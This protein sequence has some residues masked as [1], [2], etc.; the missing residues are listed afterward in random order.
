MSTVTG[1]C[2][3]RDVGGL[4]TEDGR[5][6]RA[7][8]LYR[9]D[10]PLAGDPPPAGIAAWPPRT[11]L[12][13]RSTRERAAATHP[14]AVGTTV[15]LPV[16][17]ID[18][19]RGAGAAA[20][21]LPSGVDLGRWFV[22]LYRRWLREHPTQIVEAVTVAVRAEAP[23]LVHCAAGRDRTGV[24]TALLLRAAGVRRD[25]VVADYRR[26]EENQAL[27][28]D[29]HALAVGFPGGRNAL[30][31]LRTPEAIEHVLDVVDGHPGGTTGW[32][33]AHGASAGDLER[34]SERLVSGQRTERIR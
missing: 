21:V 20:P 2:N 13:L 26:T 31:G 3:V 24:V 4:P 18:D 15:V 8:V 17:L 9:S 10:A 29:R 23:V 30:A 32:L 33:R 16:A 27:I 19:T 12:D 11:V 28:A 25:A 6:T 5:T 1:L 14:L 34:W 22:A 7:G